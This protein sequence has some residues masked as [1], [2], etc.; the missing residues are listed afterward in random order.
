MSEKTIE[1]RTIKVTNKGQ[2]TTKNSRNSHVSKVLSRKRVILPAPR[3]ACNN[4]EFM[5]YELDV[6]SNLY[7]KLY[8]QE[9]EDIKRT[10]NRLKKYITD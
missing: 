4:K 6:I 3:N 1:I 8:N 9:E 5:R 7:S 2:K 10:V